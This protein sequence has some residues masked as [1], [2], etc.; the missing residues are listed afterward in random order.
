MFKDKIKKVRRSLHLACSLLWTASILLLPTESIART[1]PS[2]G[3]ITLREQNPIYLQSLGLT[4]TRATVLPE[5]SIET[6][7]DWAYSSVFE[8]GQSATNRVTLDMEMMR[9]AAHVIYGLTS[10]FEVGIELP[11]YHSGGG[12]LDSFIQEFH[13]FFGLPNGGRE[14]VPN[15]Q[16]TYQFFSGGNL[17]YNVPSQSFMIGDITLR[18]KNHVVEETRARPALA[19]FVDIK[20]PTGSKSR[21]TGSGAPDFGVGVALEKNY[22]RIH[23]YLD[24]EYIVAGGNDSID[25]FM[26][27]A[28]IAFAAAFEVSIL[29]TWSA[30]IQ[31][32][33]SSPL[34][35]HT[36]MET[37]DGIPMNLIVGFRGEEPG[38][39]G[40]NDLF[41]QAGFAE[42]VLS[43]GPSVDFTVFLS[44][45]V[46]FHKPKKVSNQNQWLARK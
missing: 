23:G 34:L 26:R 32:N 40:G 29:D 21:G 15:N 8:Q 36:G 41:W 27:Q 10:N 24:A 18:F 35:A 39:L 2:F 33:G 42:D 11:F 28:M 38:L 4:P 6:R 5:G 37:W 44:L 12:F 9:L 1:H 31:L 17:I 16:Y 7:L 13:K 20:L 22:K 30:I 3:P 14:T 25:A 43:T 45:G 19:W 46:R